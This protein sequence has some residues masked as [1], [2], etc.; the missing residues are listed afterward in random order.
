MFA[1]HNFHHIFHTAYSH[2]PKNPTAE[3]LSMSAYTQLPKT[4]AYDNK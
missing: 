2:K 3:T 1:V 4:H